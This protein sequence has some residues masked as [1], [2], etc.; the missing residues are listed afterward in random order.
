MSE[1]ER[2]ASELAA[3]EDKLRRDR[4]MHAML[5]EL[6]AMTQSRKTTGI[7]PPIR[8]PPVSLPSAP[9]TR[10]A[11]VDKRL[12][13]TKTLRL[14]GN[15]PYSHQEVSP[16]TL[17]V[18]TT[19]KVASASEVAHDAK[20]KTA[21]WARKTYVSFEFKLLCWYVLPLLAMQVVAITL[22]VIMLRRQ[23]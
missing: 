4:E 15:Q 13:R 7:P 20:V 23:P 19:Q 21:F 1:A 12:P 6:T 8:K 11:G 16:K 22:L 2:I 14:Y 3:A 10:V 5:C 9:P 18:A 17:A